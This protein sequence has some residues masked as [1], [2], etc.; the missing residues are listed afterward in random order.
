MSIKTLILNKKYSEALEKICTT[1]HFTLIKLDI[2]PHLYSSG[3]L[4]CYPLIEA[5][6]VRLQ[7]SNIAF[8]NALESPFNILINTVSNIEFLYKTLT[9][10][11]KYYKFDDIKNIKYSHIHTLLK[12]KVLNTLDYSNSLA[13][14]NLFSIY[15]NRLS[16]ED[17]DY[18]TSLLDSNQ[19]GIIF[20]RIV[21]NWNLNIDRTNYDKECLFIEYSN[22]CKTQEYYYIEIEPDVQ[23]MID[24]NYTEHD[25]IMK[26]SM[27]A[28][29]LNT[30]GCY[31]Y[32]KKDFKLMKK[33]YMLAIINENQTAMLNLA[34]YYKN[35]NKYCE[36]INLYSIA[37]MY[38]NI[39]ALNSLLN[40]CIRVR[41]IDTLI[42]CYLFKIEWGDISFYTN[43]V[44]CYIGSHNHEMIKKYS[45]E[46]DEK[47]NKECLK[48]FILYL[49][50]SNQYI[51][52]LKYTTIGL[53]R[54]PDNFSYMECMLKY[55]IGIRNEDTIIEWFLKLIDHSI[56]KEKLQSHLENRYTYL[57]IHT[58][59]NLAYNK[60]TGKNG[61]YIKNEIKFNKTRTKHGNKS[62]EIYETKVKYFTTLNNSKNCIVC[63]KNEIHLPFDCYHDVCKNCY[64]K[65]QTCCYRC[66]INNK[67]DEDDDVEEDEDHSDD[68]A[69]ND[70]D[71]NNSDDYDEDYYEMPFG[72]DENGCEYDNAEQRDF[73]IAE[74]AEREA[75]ERENNGESEEDC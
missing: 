9:L 8:T 31:F 71:E 45:L 29:E 7:Y 60:Y 64:V 4:E 70:D 42:K 61:E 19:V 39:K 30:I 14:F 41:D 65:M 24:N 2:L 74:R 63:Y 75:R 13:F 22:D 3:N 46:G 68:D 32:H 43:L 15:Y 54:E 27:D 44:E 58:L 48:K 53:E 59:F 28:D 52:L 57:Q 72:C 69:D 6:L 21:T 11:L 33:Y 1:C 73:D 10:L 35:Q 20:N 16:K 50:N 18:I 51:D 23:K 55:S 40:F 5:L 25:I 12:S 56:Y 26:Y 66:E 34:K 38:H 62:I 67:N 36:M 17:N 37:I 47:G 49:K